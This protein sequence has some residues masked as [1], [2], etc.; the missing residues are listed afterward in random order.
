[1]DRKQFLKTSALGVGSLTFSDWA[2]QTVSKHNLQKKPNILLLF[3]DDLTYHD[4]GNPQVNTPYLNQLAGQ[5]MRF[6]RAF[7]SA[8]MCAPTRMSLYTGIHPV[9]NGAWPNHSKIYPY[10]QTWPQY[11]QGLG[12]RTALIGKRHAAPK[13]QF[14]FEFLGGRHH[15]NGKGIDIDLD[16]VRS[17]MEESKSDPW[18]LV[19]ASNQPHGPWN[20]GN[21]YSY[22]AEAIDLPPY[23]VD[24][25]ETRQA[26]TRYYAEITY[27]DEQMGTVL[28]HL[29][30]TGQKDNTIV[31]FL[32]EQGTH[33]PHCKWTCYDTGVR[34]IAVVRW[35]GVTE[36]GRRSDAIIQYVDVLPTLIDA[37]GGS[38]QKHDFDGKSFLPVLRGL[39][40]T[41][42]NYAFSEQ[43]SKGIYN[44][45]SA[46][47]IRS[48]RSDN[49]RL[50]WNLNYK[51]KFQNMVTAGYGPFESWKRKARNGDPFAIKRV[52]WYQKRPEFELYNNHKDPFELHN[53]AED[54]AYRKVRDN[55]KKQLDQWMIQQGDKGKKT[56]KKALQRQSDRWIE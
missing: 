24:T 37:I 47:G 39:R 2:E 48:V 3:A 9:R 11:L 36:A 34:S 55:L 12:Y 13:E 52:R 49:Y 44:G 35:P 27:M 28:R 54:S 46:Y 16:K 5:G 33:L 42:N 7:N 18:S 29:N 26:L 50:I 6:D 51:N 25:P 17:F 14:P 1:M 30:E 20:R 41:H 21:T 22:N 53:L 15:D 8:P 19:V 43:T 23:L 31:I 56:E 38:P 45:P 4:L 10:I 32:S 40:N